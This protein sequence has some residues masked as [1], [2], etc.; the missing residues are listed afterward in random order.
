MNAGV[1]IGCRTLRAWLQPGLL[2]QLLVRSAVEA[3]P[4]PGLIRK[5]IRP[6]RTY[7]WRQSTCYNKAGR[8]GD[9]TGGGRQHGTQRGSGPPHG[10]PQQRLRKALTER[11]LNG[12]WD[13]IQQIASNESGL[14]TEPDVC[15]VLRTFNNQFMFEYSTVALERTQF[16]INFYRQRKLPITGSAF[17][18]ECIRLNIYQNNRAT[19]YKI[20]ED[21][22]AGVLGD[23][24]AD[25]HTYVAIFNDVHASTRED[26]A[27]LTTYYDEML[28]RGI[29]PT[30]LVQKPLIRLARKIGEIPLVRALL[31]SPGT[32]KL[33]DIHSTTAAR[34]LSNKAQAYIAQY[35][36]V[37]ART[38]LEELLLYHIPKD[39]RLLPSTQGYATGSSDI[40]IPYEF[41]RTRDAFFIYVR[42]LYES[43]I[44]VYIIRHRIR[45][46]HELLDDMRRTIYLPPSRMAYNWFIRYHA[47]RK[48]IH[49]LHEI[50]D[51]ML[52]DGVAPD[53]YAYTKFITACMYQPRPRRL[54]KLVDK[55]IND[56]KLP[57]TLG[58]SFEPADGPDPAIDEAQDESAPRPSGLPEI[59][60]HIAELTSVH[61]LVFHPEDCVRFY[62]SMFLEFDGRIK[63]SRDE[64]CL[65]NAHIINAVM[66][67]YTMLER[68]SLVL[69]EFI[70]YAY[71]QSR[72][73]PHQ[74]PPDIK[75]NIV[76]VAHMFKM[77][78]DASDATDNQEQSQRIHTQM[79][80][81]GVR[82]PNST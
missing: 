44:R 6:K 26:L 8:P 47:K 60:K 14:I 79:V 21:M 39:T 16:V 23:F 37:G 41:T 43:I 65:P 11:N 42:S 36:L 24:K 64:Q 55:A 56:G 80:R 51:M 2:A 13:S 52:Q 76:P 74:P 32:A 27:L 66:C 1:S 3:T 9:Q 58:A 62:Q 12:I 50:H 78:L 29:Q 5:P 72:L 17:Y 15:Q 25:I 49:R 53:E 33:T 4:G 31:E 69:R 46:A 20:K 22:D 57:K 10:R 19:A 82:L 61:D 81:W 30:D 68:P 28:G 35:D 73:Y 38:Q 7:V 34:L 54:R 59:P 67:A 48:N 77:A 63:N 70:R 75:A 71:H 45:E 18:N 40:R